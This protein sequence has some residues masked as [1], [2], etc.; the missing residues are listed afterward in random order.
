MLNISEV[1]GMMSAVGLESIDHTVELTQVW[2]NDV[3][4]RL[5]WEE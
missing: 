5:G 3:D 1:G 2:I 4:A